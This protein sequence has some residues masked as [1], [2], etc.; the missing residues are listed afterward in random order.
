[1]TRPSG[2]STTYERPE[3]QTQPSSEAAGAASASTRLPA[4]WAAMKQ[5][6]SPVAGQHP[7]PG[8]VQAAGR[9]PAPDANQRGR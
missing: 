8:Q 7:G 1:M 3:H 4:H 5:N 6:L 2:G 9:S